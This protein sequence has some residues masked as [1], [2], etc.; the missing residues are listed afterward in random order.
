MIHLS[1]ITFLIIAV[2]NVMF[3]QNFT[4]L[5]VRPLGTN[6]TRHTL[7]MLCESENQARFPN[8]R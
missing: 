5:S 7:I 8:W 4:V 6:D 3:I 1:E 2:L